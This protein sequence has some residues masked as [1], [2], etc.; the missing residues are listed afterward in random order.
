MPG[1]VR[2]KDLLAGQ[3]ELGGDRRNVASSEDV[4]IDLQGIPVPYADAGAVEDVRV[5]IVVFMSL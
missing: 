3:D 4:R 1:V 5:N 2:T